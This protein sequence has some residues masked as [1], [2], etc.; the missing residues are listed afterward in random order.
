MRKL[1][2]IYLTLFSF[3]GV[4]ASDGYNV[5]FKQENGTAGIIEFSVDQYDFKTVNH[6]GIDYTKIL[7]DGRVETKEK[8]F[9][10]LPFVNA[11]IQ[12]G[13]LQ[14]VEVV[15]NTISYTEVQLD[16]PLVPSRGV[17]YRDQD[18]SQIPYEIAP[19][20]VVDAYYPANFVDM[21]E[22]YIIKDVRGTTVYFYPFQ[23]NAATQTVRIWTKVEVVL[24]ETEG[25]PVNPLYETSRN[26]RPLPVG[27]YEL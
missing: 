22:P 12:L 9:A 16:H 23:Y 21:A 20:S 26:G 6:G 3:L 2:F 7:F 10:E 15:F 13:N 18:P 5:N 24:K 25:E 17:I 19:E 4:M 27:F 11:N 14:H 8:G 1:V